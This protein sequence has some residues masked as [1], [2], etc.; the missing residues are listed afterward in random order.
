MEF[1]YEPG[2]IYMKNEDGKVVAEVTF[3][4]KNGIANINQT[5]VDG[6]LR[7]QGIA[8]KLVKAAADQIIKDGNSITATCSYAVKWFSKHPEYKLN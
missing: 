2:R 3:P 5:N 1:I 7:G 8:G 4:E 6:S